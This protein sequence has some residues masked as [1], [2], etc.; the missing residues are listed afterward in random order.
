[1]LF[2]LHIAQQQT[3]VCEAIA[4][5]RKVDVCCFHSPSLL[6]LLS[7]SSLSLSLSINIINNLMN[8]PTLGL[9]TGA[10]GSQATVAI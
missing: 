3:L 1:M 5:N 8:T 9:M 4:Q 6:I 2:F 7:F 10:G